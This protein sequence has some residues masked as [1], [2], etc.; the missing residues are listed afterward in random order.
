[1]NECEWIGNEPIKLFQKY[2]QHFAHTTPSLCRTKKKHTQ[3]KLIRLNVLPRP[4]HQY[5]SPPK[6]MNPLNQANRYRFNLRKC[7]KKKKRKENYCRD[8][9]SRTTTIDFFCHFKKKTLTSLAIISCRS[10]FQPK[11]F[12]GASH[13]RTSNSNRTFVQL[14]S[15][16][17]ALLAKSR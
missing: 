10:H 9:K 17:L 5:Q 4:H 14:I 1:M 15:P 2:G 13:T 8:H 6:Q 7:A 11:P 12:A 16:F 3:N